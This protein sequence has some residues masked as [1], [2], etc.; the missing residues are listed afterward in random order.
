LKTQ[1]TPNLITDGKCRYLNVTRRYTWWSW[2]FYS[3]A[4]NSPCI[5]F[6]GLCYTFIY[7]SY[8]DSYTLIQ[9]HI[10]IHG[11]YAVRERRT[12]I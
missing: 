2:W 11:K 3:G 9:T 5:T 10:R 6:Q 7:V 8:F 4:I 12:L 1:F